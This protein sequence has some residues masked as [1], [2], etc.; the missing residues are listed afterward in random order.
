VRMSMGRVN[1]ECEKPVPGEGM[2]L[3][4]FP[5]RLSP[6]RGHGTGFRWQRE[7]NEDAYF[8]GSMTRFA[9]MWPGARPAVEG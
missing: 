3:V 7:R 9:W 5:G 4:G 1:K 8:E 2:K 6:M